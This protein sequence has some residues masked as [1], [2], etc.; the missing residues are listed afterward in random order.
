MALAAAVMALREAG[1]AAVL[2][3]AADADPARAEAIGADGAVSEGID[4]VARLGELL[5]QGDHEEQPA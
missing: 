1:A 2:L 3:A 4:M 5:G